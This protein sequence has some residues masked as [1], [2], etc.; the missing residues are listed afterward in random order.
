MKLST[1][2]PAIGLL[3]SETGVTADVERSQRYAA[4]L[5]IQ[6]LN[7]Q[8][9]V[10]GREIVG[11]SHNPGGDVD[12]YRLYAED[13]IHNQDVKLLVGC[14]MSH[15]RKAVMPV[16]E[17]TDALLCYPT[18]Y[19]GF[20]YSPNIIY[21]GPAPNQNS[22]PLAAY[23]I[24]HYGERVVFIG[25]DYIYPRESNHVMRH[26]YRQHGGKVLEEI[27]ISL[28]PSEDELHHAVDRIARAQAD[29]VFSTVVG[30]GTADLYRA[31]AKRYGDAAR[32]PIASLTTSEAEVAKMGNEAAEGHVVVAPYFSSIETPT[33]RSFVSACNAF[34]P[35]DVTINAWAE[36]AYR[37]TLMLGR[38]M[39]A[40]GSCSVEDVQRELYKVRLD[41]PQGPVWVDQQNNHCYLTARIAEIDSCGEFAVKWQS[42]GPIK[43]DPYVVVHN[44]D[45]WSVSMGR[46]ALP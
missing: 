43:P 23:L 38:A 28:Y 36:A 15:T 13:L 45:D 7:S 34:F 9:G 17:R 46:V 22:A 37:Q 42:P 1:D 27:Y 21:G 14:Y 5:A 11:L 24:H 39:Q 31:I 40:A 32:P 25:S 30:T 3:F 2:Q 44:L 16:V 19:E 35:A 18:P 33:S 8:G 41:A 20:E 12:R 10:A 6:E 29:V 4:L 26:L